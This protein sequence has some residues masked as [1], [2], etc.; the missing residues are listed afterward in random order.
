MDCLD[1]TATTA[2]A[3]DIVDAVFE[4]R[5]W[6]RVY[7]ATGMSLTSTTKRLA[8]SRKQELEHVGKQLVCRQ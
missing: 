4:Q 5:V 8:E 2:Q 3:H 7:K 6:D 1:L